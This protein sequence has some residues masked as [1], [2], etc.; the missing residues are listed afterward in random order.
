MFSPGGYNRGL[1]GRPQ[2]RTLT[3]TIVQRLVDECPMSAMESAL[4]RCR[5]NVRITP[6]SGRRADIGG[7]QRSAN[8]GREQVQQNPDHLVGEREQR[9]GN[10]KNGQ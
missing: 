1:H 6:G 5:L 10:T 3:A 2:A 8:S 4:G 9:S 7:R